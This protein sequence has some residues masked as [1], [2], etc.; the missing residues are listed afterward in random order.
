[1]ITRLIATVLMLASA[2]LPQTQTSPA[3]QITS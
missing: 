1:M 3:I 2:A